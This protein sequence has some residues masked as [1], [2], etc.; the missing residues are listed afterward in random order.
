MTT[1]VAFLFPGQGSQA[2]GMGVDVYAASTAARRVF[3]AA[4]DALGFSLSAICFHG[5]DDV[6]RATINAQPAIVTVSLALLAA[7]QEA[8]SPHASSWASPLLPSYTAGHSVGECSALVAAGALGI[9]DAVRM[10][11]ERGRFMHDEGNAC[12][13][14]MAAVIGMEAAQVQEI[15]QQATH[16][17]LA[18]LSTGSTTH[19]GQGRVII[20]NY[21]APGQI[22]ISGDQHALAL[23]TDLAEARGAKRVM[24]LS[25]SGAFHSLIMQP[26]TQKLAEVISQVGLHDV[27][28]PIISNITATPLQRAEDLREELIQ[29]LAAPVQWIHSIEYLMREGV[30]TFIEIGPGQALTGMVKR[31]AKDCIRINIGC[32]A[33]IEKAVARVHDSGLLD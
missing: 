28:I 20:A 18:A 9:T 33:D 29:Q 10:V 27:T 4:D 7:F 3:E 31:I 13:G 12:P 19:A 11:R 30:T 6:L 23:A 14:G 1:N 26:A 8:L 22:V 5:P 25:V 2:V 32:M 21:N 16:E 24:P 17:A 15:C